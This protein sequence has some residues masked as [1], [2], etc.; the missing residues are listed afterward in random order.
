M[1]NG[2]HAEREVVTAA[3]AVP[4]RQPRVNDKR[5]DPAT[6]RSGSGSPRDPARVGTQSPRVAEVLPL[7]YLH[8]LSSSDFG[9]G[10]KFENGVLVERPDESA[11]G[12][13]HAHDALI[14]RP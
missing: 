3:G 7:L 2:Y 12:D 4:V 11:S 6:H 8:G 9:A 10:A 13:T 1:R 5:I 14:H